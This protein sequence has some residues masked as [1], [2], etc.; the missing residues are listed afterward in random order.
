M[1]II[2]KYI[3]EKEKR[4]GLLIA[5]FP[6]ANGKYDSVDLA[7]IYSAAG[8]DVL[9]IGIPVKNPY[10]D[11]D[12]I[13]TVMK[14]ALELHKEIEWYMNEI[15]RIRKACPEIVVE[16]FTYKETYSDTGLAAFTKK[17]KATGVDCALI[18]DMNDEEFADYYKGEY[19]EEFDLL[20]F[21]PFNS[22]DQFVEDLSRMPMGGYVFL[23][24]VDGKTGARKELQEGLEEK[25]RRAKRAF[26][27]PVCVGFGIS[28]PE[29]ASQITKMGADGIIIGSIAVSF[30]LNDTQEEL[31][32]KLRLYKQ[33][34][35]N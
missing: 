35:Q 20:R 26:D 12:A 11:G 9:E 34:L 16:V 7:K 4:K 13:K 1:N 14:G 23:Q 33:A 2:D 25:I 30:V 29:H 8:V 3:K 31:K 27:I 21:L 22:S 32:S 6:L 17:L 10:L 19:E 24:A 15:K 18:T 5:Y 28:T